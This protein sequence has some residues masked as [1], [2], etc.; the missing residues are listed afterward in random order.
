MQGETCVLVRTSAGLPSTYIFA[1]SKKPATVKCTHG[2]SILSPSSA[3][4]RF[5]REVPLAGCRDGYPRDVGQC[6]RIARTRALTR[7]QP[8]LLLLMLLGALVGLWSVF[9][10]VD[11]LTHIVLLAIDL[12]ALL[13]SQ[14]TAVGLSV[15]ANF[16]VDVGF[17]RFEAA[18]LTR[19]QTSG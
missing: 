3:P 5:S 18:G 11:G 9:V 6:V 4:V 1:E 2:I 19:S 14:S 13:R 8:V 16:A 15:V 10:L 17:A 7:K 12:L